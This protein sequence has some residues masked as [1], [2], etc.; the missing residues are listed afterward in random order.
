MLTFFIPNS[1]ASRSNLLT[2]IIL[3]ISATSI[4]AEDDYIDEADLFDDIQIVTSATRLKQKISDAPV[5]VTIIDSKMIEASGATEIHELF[6]LVP[7]YFSF[8]VWGNQF[9]VS[10]HFEPSEFSPELEVQVNG[11]SVYE[12]LFTTVDWTSLGI[13]VADVDFI[14]VV[15]GSSA[16]T[17][18]SNAFLGSINI[19]TKDILSR[20]RA[21]IRSTLGNIGRKH[22][23]LNHSGDIKDIDYALSLVYK[24]NTGFPALDTITRKRDQSIDDRESLH[25]SMQG[26]YTP[27][28]ENQI[29]FE[30]GLGETDLELPTFDD[31]R[32]Y[33]NTDRDNNYQKIKWINKSKGLEKSLQFYHNYL[34][35]F[36]DTNVGLLSSLLNVAPEQIPSIFP[37]QQDLEVTFGSRDTYS[38]RFDIEYE[39]KNVSSKKVNYVWGGGARQERVNSQL[40]F[41]NGTKSENR[42]RLF[43]NVDWK[44]N[45]KLNTN[46]GLLAENTKLSGTVYSPRVAFNFHPTER[47]TFR[48]S[49]TQGKHVPSVTLQNL[50]TGVRFPDGSLIDVGTIRADT[51]S[52]EKVTAYELAY[53]AKT[54]DSNTKFEVKLFRE[55]MEDFLYLQVRP[56][57][58]INQ[59][60]RVWDNLRN[61]T[62]KGLEVQLNHKFDAIPDFDMRL[63]YAYFDTNNTVHRDIRVP[64]DLIPASAVPRHSGTLMLT[65]K[66]ANQFDLSSVLQYQSDFRDRGVQIK[67][68]DLRLGKQLKLANT[69][70]KVDL[71]IQNAFNEYKDFSPRNVLGARAFIRMQ[72]DF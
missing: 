37:G 59:E 45:K 28:I 68:V 36:D 6:R 64:N 29:E 2:V 71:V 21:T 35:W 25:L 24:T 16:S 67:R 63:A 51:L 17:Y 26:S 30:L 41:G 8:S 44:I 15:R 11:R 19:V 57:P 34:G 56:F 39:Y 18:G 69:K 52:R 31:P 32:G 33:K 42:Y 58:D 10:T 20:P 4:F 49:A 53:M 46:I 72:L 55:E 9:G 70:G 62:T 48:I 27:N 47:H 23:T 12:P 5:S 1:N 43:G 14:E 66:L 7:G 38:E 60:V 54:R 22:L 13:D 65:K 3:M 50:N 40:L 61:L